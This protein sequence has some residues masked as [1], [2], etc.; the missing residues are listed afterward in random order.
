MEILIK[1]IGTMFL[2]I[3]S[4]LVVMYIQVKSKSSSSLTSSILSLSEEKYSYFFTYTTTD[5]APNV[6]YSS[7]SGNVALASDTHGNVYRTYNKGLTWSTSKSLKINNKS[8]ASISGVAFS[9]TA[10]E[11]LVSS[12]TDD[13]IFY[14]DDYGETFTIQ[15]S[16]TCSVMSASSDLENVVCIGGTQGE[17][18]DILYSSDKGK[19]WKKSKV[20]KNQWIGIA[21]NSDFSNIVAIVQTSDDYSYG[22]TDGGKTFKVLANNEENS[23]S[24]FSAS[25]NLEVMIITDENSRNTHYSVDGGYNWKQL[26]DGAGMTATYQSCAVSG[27]GL[28]F[29]LGWSGYPM[30]I[31][32]GCDASSDREHCHDSWVTQRHGSSTGS[33]DTR[34]MSFNLDG[35]ILFAVDGNNKEIVVGSL[36]E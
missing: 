35:T 9:H 2:I 30:E 32:H 22:S 16:R 25:R 28:S 18:N 29:G 3:S 17:T 24:C 6:I 20:A 36:S 21:S 33:F 15:S 1:S 8:Y 4:I 11:V 12:N 19:S 14:S 26:Y 7:I 23:W 5:H 31:E 27:D 10:K 13:T 34:S